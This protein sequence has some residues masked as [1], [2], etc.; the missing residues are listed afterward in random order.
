MNIH[1]LSDI[2]DQFHIGVIVVVRPT[3][4]LNIL[5]RH[6]DVV[7]VRTQILGGCHDGELYGPF[8]PEGLVC[9]FSHGPDFLDGCDTI[10]GNEDL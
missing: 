5:I 10:V 6:S 3:G 2:D 4:D 8:V 9:P 1:S 7:C